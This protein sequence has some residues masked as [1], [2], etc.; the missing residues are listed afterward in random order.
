M[1]YPERRERLEGGGGGYGDKGGTRGG[2]RYARYAQRRYPTQN[3]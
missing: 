3:P 1:L 2:G